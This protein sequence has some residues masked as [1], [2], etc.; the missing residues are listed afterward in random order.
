MHSPRS[1]LLGWA[2][3]GICHCSLR[4]MAPDLLP[5]C[6]SP[7]QH[8]VQA[9]EGHRCFTLLPAILLS[10][11]LPCV[12]LRQSL[13]GHGAKAAVQSE[14]VALLQVQPSQAHQE[15]LCS[16]SDFMC[17]AAT[18]VAEVGCCGDREGQVSG[19]ADCAQHSASSRAPGAHRLVA[20]EDEHVARWEGHDSGVPAQGGHG[21]HL[22][23]V[24]E[25]G[26]EDAHRLG[27]PS[28]GGGQ[29]RDDDA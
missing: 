15:L 26:A 1:H 17:S 20:A 6:H 14:A 12:L 10:T 21:G 29:G 28:V 27:S 11:V 2:S 9:C 8:R 18:M 4:R 19:P 13:C 22:A 16:M 24:P 5:S 7:A 3:T 23:V 25:L